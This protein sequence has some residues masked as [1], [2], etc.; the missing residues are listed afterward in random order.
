[1]FTWLVL[2]HC[3]DVYDCFFVYVIMYSAMRSYPPPPP[4]YSSVNDLLILFII[5]HC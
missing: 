5:I 2:V 4:D 1:M 3:T